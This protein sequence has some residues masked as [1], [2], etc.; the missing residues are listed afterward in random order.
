MTEINNGIIKTVRT[1]WAKKGRD[2]EGLFVAEGTKCVRDTWGAFKCRWLIAT[3]QWYDQMGTA[4]MYPH[5]V[6]A[7]RREMARMSQFDTASEVI[8][9]YETPQRSF[10]PEQVRS[11]DLHI[12]LDDIQDPGNLGT[13]MRL[14]DWYGLRHIFASRQ[15]V[16]VFNH[17]VVQATMGAIARV[18]VHYVDLEELLS[19]YRDVP[20]WGTFLDGDNIYATQLEPASGFVI[21]GN[22]G[23]GIGRDVAALVQ[24][25]LLIPAAPHE[26]RGS[27]SLNV[28][29]AAAITLSEFMREKLK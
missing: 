11:G 10:T 6:I 27:E 18:A 24:R 14:A 9:V 23:R 8:A 1:L 5:V 3:R 25:R 2:A 19:D 15:T 16:D 26:G 17:K 29:V 28:G 20:S 4:E 22:E 21:F 7:P 13:I 12:V